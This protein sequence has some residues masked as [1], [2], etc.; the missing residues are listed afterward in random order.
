MPKAFTLM[1]IPELI[2][3]SERVKH[4]QHR[5]LRKQLCQD[6]H[7]D[8]GT[9]IVQRL[10]PGETGTF[11]KLFDYEELRTNKLGGMRND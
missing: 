7:R 6:C 9:A 8:R 3:E 4:D 5:H 10:R 2:L 1:A 11:P